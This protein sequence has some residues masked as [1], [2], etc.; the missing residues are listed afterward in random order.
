M[1]IINSQ[2]KYIYQ[3]SKNVWPAEEKEQVK[4]KI[5]W[6]DENPKSITKKGKYIN[7]Y[8]LYTYIHILI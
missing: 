4:D 8:I 2:K 5:F 7:T 1:K 3:S 6:F